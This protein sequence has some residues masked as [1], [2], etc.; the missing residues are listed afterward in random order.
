MRKPIT[1]IILALC[2][3]LVWGQTIIMG[4]IMDETTNES[5][6]GANIFVV[7]SSV[8][9]AT[10]VNGNFV[11]EIP[12][13]LDS[14]VQVEI[15][16]T[17]YSTQTF[18]V[19]NIGRKETINY[20]IKADAFQLKNVV[21]S[22]N[23]R[24][25]SSQLV[26]MSITTLIPR[27][28][29]RTGAKEFR[30]YASGIANL[31]FGT[32][33]AGLWGRYDNGISIRGISG[34]NTT[35][36]YLD[37][38]PFPENLDP[39]L[40]DIAQVEI[41]KGPQGTLY[42]SRNMGG[43]VKVISNR[44]N[45]ESIEGSIETTFAKVKEGDF[46]YGTQAVLNFPLSNKLAF[47]GVGFYDFETG[48]FD[49]KIN[50]EANI[51]NLGSS[52]METYLP[53][54]TPFS[55][56]LDNCPTCNLNDQENIDAEKN[57]GF[58][59]T[60]GYFPNDKITLTPK[61]IIQKQIGAGY[62]FAEGEIGNFTQ[63][64]A[65]G[66][67]ETYSDDWK[68]YS[69]TGEFEMENGK[70]VSSLSFLDRKILEVDDDGESFSRL[71][72]LYDGEENLDFF[73]GNISKQVNMQQFNYELRFQSSL[74][75]KFNY[76]LGL[77]FSKQNE[78]ESWLS[79]SLGAGSYFSL[80]YYEEPDFA[81]YIEDEAPNFYE[82]GGAYENKELAFFGEAYYSFTKKLKATIGLRYFEASSGIDS[83]ETGF[84]VDTEYIEVIGRSR[85]SDIIPKLNL[86]YQLDKNKMFYA[87]VGKGYRLGDLNEIV[88]QI[89]CGD[90][91]ADLPDGTHPKIFQSDYLWNYEL[92]FKGTWANGKIVTN[93]AI[94][95]NDWQNL[96][97]HQTLD[98][99]YSF[100]SNVGS[101]HTTGFEIEAKTKISDNLEVGGGFGFT[102]AR[103]D[104][105]GQ[106]LEAEAGDKILFTPSVTGNLN[107]EYSKDFSAKGSWYIHANLQH[108]GK[109]FNTF[110][111]EE[112]EEAYR[113]FDAY[114][115]INARA[116]LRLSKYEFSLFAQ[117]LTNTQANFGDIF[118]IAVDIPDRPRY[119][120]NRPITVGLQARV[121][122]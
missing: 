16:Y 32:Q 26:P 121:S 15:S 80:Y 41:L 69:V 73:A 65:S 64:R 102:E 96:Q 29:R 63:V 40:I 49:R 66:V 111:P 24:T 19:E 1:V 90:E 35:S 42:G 100:T 113:I 43:A 114:T 92:G 68:H 47:R 51:L 101:A 119:A 95:Y 117:N 77:F 81:E 48:V 89:F 110:S 4:K 57:Y 45:V 85:E 84:L 105:G 76:T 120:T 22:A 74:K 79:N 14:I 83:Y 10:D 21:V 20:S 75:K 71:F 27:Q 58:Q 55:I 6:I 118:S 93:G 97:Q 38:T 53:D 23:K 11:L 13:D 18:E 106:N 115:I 7:N 61:V 94:F 98:C 70:L 87:N 72:E 60:L 46:N 91:L 44:P 5:L 25:Q 33:G 31:S 28:L 78:E 17:G 62:D 36:M 12:E 2:P 109:R 54:G 88:P 112:P 37:E 30:D 56:A 107:A 8:G 99:G 67:P 103:I 82:F 59:A 104:E 86:T 39:R 108:V 116:G 9:T 3:I 52:S 50:R 122:F 34:K